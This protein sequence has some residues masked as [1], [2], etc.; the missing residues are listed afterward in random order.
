M[1]NFFGIKPAV[2]EVQQVVPDTVVIQTV[3]TGLV[4]GKCPTCGRDAI[5]QEK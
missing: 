5:S 4:T 1:D 2:K 3:A